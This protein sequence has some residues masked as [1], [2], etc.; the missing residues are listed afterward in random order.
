MSIECPYLKFKHYYPGTEIEELVDWC[1]F[2]N[3]E[4]PAQYGRCLIT[5]EDCRFLIDGQCGSLFFEGV[6][7]ERCPAF[8]KKR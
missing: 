1:Q 4:C 8:E 2:K 5:C 7:R 3:E 6:I